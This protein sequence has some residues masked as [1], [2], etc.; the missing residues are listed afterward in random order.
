M[1]RT[2]CK[3]SVVDTAYVH[4]HR[5]GTIITTGL[6]E[7]RF[8]GSVGCRFR[9]WTCKRRS[10][11]KNRPKQVECNDFDI[12]SRNN[13]SRVRNPFKCGFRA[14]VPV[15]FLTLLGAIHNRRGISIKGN[16]HGVQHIAIASQFLSKPRDPFSIITIWAKDRI[17]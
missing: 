17:L 1:P 8:H 11:Y 6:P 16:M 14:V 3:A 9:G 4:F 2:P 13:R 5:M 12:S 10:T 7:Q 15:H